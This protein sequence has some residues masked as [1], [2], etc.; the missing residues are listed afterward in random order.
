MVR[1]EKNLLHWRLGFQQEPPLFVGGEFWDCRIHEFGKGVWR[2][3]RW[4][5]RFGRF[6]LFRD[7]IPVSCFGKTGCRLGTMN[8]WIRNKR[9]SWFAVRCRL[10]CKNLADVRILSWAISWPLSVLRWDLAKQIV[11]SR[12]TGDS[13]SIDIDDP[14]DRVSGNGTQNKRVP[15]EDVQTRTPKP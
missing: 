9:R 13:R 11:G 2:D 3:E 5:A 12:D 8:E 10:I 1:K 7:W 4:L 15:V 6:L 14:V